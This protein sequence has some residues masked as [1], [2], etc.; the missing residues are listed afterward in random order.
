MLNDRIKQLINR[1]INVSKSKPKGGGGGGGAQLKQC[2]DITNQPIKQQIQKPNRTYGFDIAHVSYRKEIS[3]WLRGG[4][5]CLSVG[6]IVRNVLGY[7]LL[8]PFI[9][10]L[11]GGVGFTQAC[12]HFA[13]I[14]HS[15]CKDAPGWLEHA[16]RRSY[17]NPKEKELGNT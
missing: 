6:T 11:P 9:H 14:V 5:S 16:G 1:Q 4:N 8:V 12:H 10:A 13:F 2:T 3:S 15:G 17:G 7:Q